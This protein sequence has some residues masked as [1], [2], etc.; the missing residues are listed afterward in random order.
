LACR[1]IQG[2]DRVEVDPKGPF[3]HLLLIDQEQEILPDFRCAEMV[4]W[5]PI[6][7]GQLLDGIDVTLLGLGGQ[8]PEL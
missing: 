1:L 7:L 4:R 8:T 2:L 5:A 3:S 6:V